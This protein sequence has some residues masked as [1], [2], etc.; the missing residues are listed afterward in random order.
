MASSLTFRSDLTLLVTL[1]A[2]KESDAR[3]APRSRSAR[4]H[5]G[6]F[7]SIGKL[8]LMVIEFLEQM[9]PTAV[10]VRAPS[11][12]ILVCGGQMSENFDD[13]PL[14][15]RDVFFK[16]LDGAIPP[17]AT[18][19]RAE[20]VNA[21]HIHKASYDDF[22]RFESDIAQL[23]EII[24]LFCES[25]GSFCELGSF[26]SIEE[27]RHR[28]LVVI[29][30]KHFN[31]QSYIRLGPLQS[32]LNQNDSAV[33]TFTFS[34]L[35]AGSK[36]FPSV[37]TDKLKSLLRPKIDKRLES[38]PS[39]TTLNTK[40]E[41]HIIKAIV[42]FCQ[43]FGALERAEILLALQHIE[44]NIDDRDLKRFILCASQLDWIKEI[45]KGDRWLIFSNKALDRDAAQFQLSKS[46]PLPAS[47]T[48]RRL[49]ILEGW[50][51]FDEDRYNAILEVRA[52]SWVG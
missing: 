52:N 22:L 4:S 32:L 25:E 13:P 26:C 34:S 7:R 43:E 19:L 30:E 41:G 15:L 45:R 51:R 20:D 44:I 40:K 49:S 8:I 42:G 38:I 39:D 14:S 6:L 12:F 37:N 17:N 48:K 10:W 3:S 9:D 24:L 21:F 5:V 36:H 35:G 23:C 16:I 18:L 2:P 47:R 27:I 11:R 50:R 29:E 31:A 33:V 28:T 46:G 1:V